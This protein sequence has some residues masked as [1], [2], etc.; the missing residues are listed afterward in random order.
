MNHP[1]WRTMKNR[2]SFLQR[3]PPLPQKEWKCCQI[4]KKVSMQE[5]SPTLT[6]DCSILGDVFPRWERHL[7][8]DRS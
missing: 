6:F 4:R 3:D 7:F 5:R 1:I 2:S 8:L